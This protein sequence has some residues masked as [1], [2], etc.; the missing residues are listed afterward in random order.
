MSVAKKEYKRI[1]VKTL[2]D[3][4][5]NG[6]KIS[7]LTAYDYSMAR[8]LDEAGTDVLL[9]GDSASNV[10][11]GHETTLPITL[12]QMIYHA[13][14]VV[15]AIERCLIVGDLPFGSYQ[16]SK[17]QAYANAV[18]LMQ[19]GAHIVKLEGGELQVETIKFLSE[20]GIAVCA[21]IGLTPQSVHKLGGFKVQGRGDTAKELIE[22]AIGVEQAG[23]CA[24]VLEAVPQMLAAQ[25]TEQLSIPTIGIG[26]GKDCDGQVLV[27]Q[28]MIG[29]YPRKSPKFCKNFM[30]G[31]DSI[32]QAV[33]NY[34]AEVKSAEF[35]APEHCFD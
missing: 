6:E 21:H 4:K 1:T 11:A 14:S 31:S 10:M 25:I 24:V 3:M 26:A 29:L 7:M 32:A 28:D 2:V 34:V 33:E 35:P 9:V 22:D 23:A 20:R 27:L 16:I 12:D 8:I 17:E 30:S 18:K 5:A 19:A 15:R 13:S